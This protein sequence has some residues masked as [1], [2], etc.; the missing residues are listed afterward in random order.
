MQEG[1][2]VRRGNFW[3]LRYYRPVLKNGV[4]KNAQTATKLVRVSEQF[5]NEKAVRAAGL[6]GARKIT[7]ILGPLNAGTATADSTITLADFIEHRY[8]PYVREEKKPKTSK[9]YQDCLRILAPH[10]NGRELGAVKT[11]DIETILR[12]VRTAKPRANSTMKHLKHFLSGAMRFAV[13]QGLLAHNPVPAAVPPKGITTD[14]TYAYSF[15]EV[16]AMLKLLAEPARTIV[17]T[18]SLTGLRMSELPGLKWT[19]VR[20]DSIYVQR[21]VQGGVVLETKTEDS[22]ALVP[23]VD[24]VRKALRKHRKLS[25]SEYVFAGLRDGKPIVMDN[26]KRR[27]VV[28][29]LK[30]GIEWHGFHA[31]RRGLATELNRLGVKDET[32]AELL[33]HK[34]GKSVTRLYIKA[35]PEVNHEAMRQAE[36]AFLA[37]K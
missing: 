9:G 28:P 13:R 18:L 4:K 33:R 16:Q 20:E 10:L 3:Y 34:G 35:V 14:D 8:M 37:A 22:K 17:L 11:A 5:P 19:D 32:I 2:I 29:R 26:V 7:E 31:F 21:Q 1:S 24:T 15:A 27:L 23:L 36:Q 30:N 6:T 12:D 25:T